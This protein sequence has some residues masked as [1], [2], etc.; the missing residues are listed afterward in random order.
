MGLGYFSFDLLDGVVVSEIVDDYD[1]QCEGQ[2]QRDAVIL[3]EL[4]LE[5]YDTSI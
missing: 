3:W 5:V 4:R 1:R 2:K